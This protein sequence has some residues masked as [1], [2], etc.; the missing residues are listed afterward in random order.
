MFFI[1]IFILGGMIVAGNYFSSEMRSLANDDSSPKWKIFAN[2]IGG[3]LMYGGV[4]IMVLD[5]IANVG[6]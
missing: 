4:F 2:W 3:A 5:L 6:T 1:Q